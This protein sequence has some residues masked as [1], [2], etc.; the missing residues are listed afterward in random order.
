MRA[1]KDE[2]SAVLDALRACSLSAPDSQGNFYVNLA[3]AR[4]TLARFCAPHNGPTELRL[5]MLMLLEWDFNRQGTI[6][7]VSILRMAHAVTIQ[8]RG[9]KWVRAAAL[10]TFLRQ[11]SHFNCTLPVSQD[12]AGSI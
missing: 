5:L 3:S 2:Q 9:A 12:Q 4:G 11:E 1:A 6:D 10:E 7:A 8:K